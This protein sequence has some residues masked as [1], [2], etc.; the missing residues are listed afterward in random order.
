VTSF[1]ALSRQHF[2][3]E[4]YAGVLRQ[5]NQE[6]NVH[7]GPGA[8]LRE[9]QKVIVV[10]RQDLD[11]IV[12]A[13]SQSAAA[14]PVVAGSPPNASRPVASSAHK[15]DARPNPPRPAPPPQPNWNTA[16][17]AANSGGVY[18]VQ[19]NGEMLFEIARRTLG[20]GRRWS[21]IYR[22]NPN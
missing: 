21:E 20:D 18:T 2:G 4:E 7:T 3:T 5:I 14:S 15:P 10:P 6:F 12:R 1:E 9:G 17:T 13:R 11:T 22:L 19:G 8:S 16:T